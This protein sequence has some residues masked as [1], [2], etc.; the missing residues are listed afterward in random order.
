MYYCG[1]KLIKDLARNENE[2]VRKIFLNERNERL[3][4]VIGIK[5]KV[6]AFF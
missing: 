2:L 5:S 4:D 3:L 1:L 6:F